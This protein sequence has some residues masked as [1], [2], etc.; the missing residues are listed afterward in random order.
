MRS[1]TSDRPRPSGAL[2]VV[3]ALF[4]ALCTLAPRAMATSVQELVR[5]EGQGVSTLQ[6]FGLVVGRFQVDLAADV[7]DRVDTLSLSTVVS[8]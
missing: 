3:A 2:V 8:F 6:G 7:S 4:A 5:L 1:S